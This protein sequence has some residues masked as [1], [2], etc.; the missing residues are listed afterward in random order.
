VNI[1]LQTPNTSKSYPGGSALHLAV[2]NEKY[3]MCKFLIE[4]GI[5]INGRDVNKNTAAHIT[6]M[7]GSENIARLLE[8]S[9]A[10]FL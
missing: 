2:A 3:D 6:A 1:N 5:S 8:K 4:L 10:D 9:K 7:N